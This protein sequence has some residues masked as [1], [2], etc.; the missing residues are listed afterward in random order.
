MDSDSVVLEDEDLVRY[1]AELTSCEADAVRKTLLYRTVAAGG[2]EIIEKGHGVKE[3]AYAR[4]ACAKV[5]QRWLVVVNSR[6]V[7]ERW[8]R[9]GEKERLGEFLGMVNSVEDLTLISL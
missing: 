9:S 2:G 4:D 7:Q 3:A 8:E 6:E 5:G 1:I